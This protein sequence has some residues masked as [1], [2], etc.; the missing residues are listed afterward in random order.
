MHTTT[1]P[2]RRALAFQLGRAE[3]VWNEIIAVLE[4]RF[5][6]VVLEW[7][8]FG[9]KLL[10]GAFLWFCTVKQ[11]K[12]MLLFLRAARRKL[13][14]CVSL[15]EHA[16]TQA[17]ASDLPATVKKLIRKARPHPT[18]RYIPFRAK[19][20]DVAMVVELIRIKTGR[21]AASRGRVE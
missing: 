11:K 20:A 15:S 7:K 3:A 19:M 9:R 13:H 16:A 17:L 5:G 1:A 12:R 21:K 2:T 18:G 14:V 8:G 10:P 6:Q 4:E